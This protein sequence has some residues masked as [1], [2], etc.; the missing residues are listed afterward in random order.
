M[1]RNRTFQGCSSFLFS[2]CSSTVVVYFS[3]SMLPSL[4][5][6]YQYFVMQCWG[7]GWGE[8]S[9]SSTFPS[10]DLLLTGSLCS[11]GV[12]CHHKLSPLDIIGMKAH[13]NHRRREDEARWA[14]V[15]YIWGFS[16]KKFKCQWTGMV[17]SFTKNRFG[18]KM[19][20]LK[21]DVQE[22][23]MFLSSPHYPQL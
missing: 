8:A 13:R 11:C 22:Q 20:K 21:K 3:L 5:L 19:A 1:W 14:E 12:Q 15:I 17:G 18:W 2:N 7:V 4:E 10:S 6:K 9:I 23:E 16:R